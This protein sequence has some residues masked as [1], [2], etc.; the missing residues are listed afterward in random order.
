M[1]LRRFLHSLFTAAPNAHGA[2]VDAAREAFTKSH[3]NDCHSESVLGSANDCVFVRF[4]Y[5]SQK[6]QRRAFY[7]VNA[8]GVV[9]EVTLEDVRQFVE[10]PW[11]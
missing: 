10:L 9:R 8:T 6:P 2:A 7:S 1:S 4:C 5:G 11:M 3:G